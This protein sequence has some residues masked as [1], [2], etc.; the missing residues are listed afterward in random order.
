MTI[1]YCSSETKSIAQRYIPRLDRLLAHFHPP[2]LPRS[3][4]LFGA[5]GKTLSQSQPSCM[6]G[7]RIEELP[8][9]VVDHV[10]LT[11]IQRFWPTESRLHAYFS[12]KLVD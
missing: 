8:L 12:K 5:V 7:L 1:F 3:H 9:L 2:K 6:E 4:P 11:G 10:V